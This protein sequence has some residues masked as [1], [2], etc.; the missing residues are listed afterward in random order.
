MN[1]ALTFQAHKSLLKFRL[2][3]TA[4]HLEYHILTQELQLFVKK[5]KT[6][7]HANSRLLQQH[8]AKNWKQATAYIDHEVPLLEALGHP[9]YSNFNRSIADFSSRLWGTGESQ[10][11]PILQQCSSQS[12]TTGVYL[13]HTWFTILALLKAV[14]CCEDHA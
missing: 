6:E 1:S 9:Q 4:V 5:K 7:W 10:R 12:L 13:Q 3:Q 8:F 11:M 14:S 2:L